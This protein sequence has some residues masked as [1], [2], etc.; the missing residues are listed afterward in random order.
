[1][2]YGPNAAAAEELC[3]E[4]LPRVRA[5]A[6]RE[7]RVTVVGS[8]PPPGVARLAEIPGVTV[9]GTVP[10][11]TPHYDRAAVAVIPVRAGG[12]TRIKMLEAFAHRVPRS[13]HPM[14]A[15]GLDVTPGQHLLVGDDPDALAAACVALLR[16]PALGRQLAADAYTLVRRRYALPV[17]ARAIRTLYRDLREA[18]AALPAVVGTERSRIR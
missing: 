18:P 6:D 5:A 15:E 14:A 4:V 12:G 7:V 10:E 13:R 8:R 2:G 3:R 16:E 11:V 17:V 1:M 9:T